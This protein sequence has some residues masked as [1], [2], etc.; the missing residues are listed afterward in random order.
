M[1]S[2]FYQAV[3]SGE[4]PTSEASLI[5]TENHERLFNASQ[6]YYQRYMAQAISRDMRTTAVNTSASPSLVIGTYYSPLKQRVFQNHPSKLA[7]QIILGSMVLCGTLAYLFSDMASRGQE[8]QVDCMC[9]TEPS[10]ASSQ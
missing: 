3:L 9:R 5:G 2:T 7:L 6:P 1:V 10:P 8:V 4:T